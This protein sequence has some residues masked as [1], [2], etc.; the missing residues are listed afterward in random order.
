MAQVDAGLPAQAC[1]C[2]A[3][4]SL[5]P[6]DDLDLRQ[7]FLYGTT[8]WFADYS[9]RSSIEASNGNFTTHFSG[10]GDRRSIRALKGRRKRAWLTCFGIIAVAIRLMRSRYGTSPSLLAEGEQVTAPLPKPLRKD[11]NGREKTTLNVQ[12]FG[13][14][15][16]RRKTGRPPRGTPKSKPPTGPPTW[17]VT[18]PQAAGDSVK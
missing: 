3:Q 2:S 15:K 1:A 12:V 14:R 10:L 17:A 11:K 16:A 9:R 4:P 7:R 8:K 5:G 6:D 18:P 13:R